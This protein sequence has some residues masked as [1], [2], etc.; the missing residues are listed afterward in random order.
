MGWLE[1][2][3]WAAWAAIAVLLSVAELISLDL[4]LIMLAAGAGAGAL[5]SLVS[6]SVWID[7][8]VAAI[9]SVGMLAIV[10]PS[11]MKRL[12][13]GPELTTG[14]SALVGH[15]AV[16]L[17]TVDEHGGRIKLAGEV[18]S[19]RFFDPSGR[20]EPGT[21]VEVYG[22]DGATAVVYPVD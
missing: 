11:M 3:A 10:R 1:E 14:H 15:K 13:S 19:A 7:L 16:V 2:N 4:V 8:A 18:W 6:P 17:E 21:E 20:V 22:I 9:V 5:S 12:H